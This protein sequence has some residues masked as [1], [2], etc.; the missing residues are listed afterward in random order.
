MRAALVASL[1]FIGLIATALRHN[2]PRPP[3]PWKR[4]EA[5]EVTNL[6][7]DIVGGAHPTKAEAERLALEEAQIK[8]VAY[9]RSLDPPVEWV[10]S[11]EYVRKL[12]GRTPIRYDTL[13]AVGEDV[14]KAKLTVEVNAGDRAEIRRFDRDQR[15]QFRMTLLAKL[16]AGVLV[17]LG[18]VAGYVHLEDKTKGYFTAWLKLATALVIAAAVVVLLALA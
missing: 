3:I 17:M 15:S 7:A 6:K 12:A 5:R 1:I 18:A 11:T 16:L 13:H 2:T 10:P 4:A 8:V 9:L 14:V